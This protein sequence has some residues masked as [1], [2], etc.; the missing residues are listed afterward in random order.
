M[1][2]IKGVTGAFWLFVGPFVLGLL[3]FVYAPILWSVIL[4][5]NRAQNTVTPGHWVGLQ[6]YVDLL[7]PGPFLSSLATSCCS[8]SS[9]CR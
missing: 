8:R 5:F 9:S 7:R 3:I 1:T 2:P 4:S 6:N